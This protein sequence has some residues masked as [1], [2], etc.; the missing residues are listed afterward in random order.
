MDDVVRRAPG[1]LSAEGVRG[2][3]RSKE[4]ELVFGSPPLL[5]LR[6]WRGAVLDGGKDGIASGE[7]EA[8]PKLGTNPPFGHGVF[9]REPRLAGIVRAAEEALFF[10]REGNEDDP[11]ARLA[12]SGC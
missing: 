5:Q 1:R 2:A 11:P 7:W 10:P 3:R 9:Q 4:T 8:G 6:E 12:G